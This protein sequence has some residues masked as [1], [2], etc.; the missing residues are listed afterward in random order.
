MNDTDTNTLKEFAAIT[1]NFLHEDS[2]YDCSSMWENFEKAHQLK[3]RLRALAPIIDGILN[4][5]H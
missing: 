3:R 4:L 2:E 1:L 5:K